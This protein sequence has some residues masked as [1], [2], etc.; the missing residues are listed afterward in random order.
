VIYGK[1]RYVVRN[2]HVRNIVALAGLE[3]GPSVFAYAGWRGQEHTRLRVRRL[4]HAATVPKH[5]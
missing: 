5:P 3:R 1:D 2:D 4:V